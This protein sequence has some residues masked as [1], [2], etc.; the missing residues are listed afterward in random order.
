M[1]FLFKGRQLSLLIKFDLVDHVAPINVPI[2]IAICR[3]IHAW[4]S[5]TLHEAEE[6]AAHC[7]TFR[8]SDQ[9]TSEIFVLC[10]S[11]EPHH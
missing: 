2:D 7:G 9:E 11:Y 5:H 6:H 8:D 10:R 1:T 4:A 3:K